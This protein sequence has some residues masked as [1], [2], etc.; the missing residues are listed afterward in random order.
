MTY[1]LGSQCVFKTQFNVAVVSSKHH[2]NT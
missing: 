2:F 1:N